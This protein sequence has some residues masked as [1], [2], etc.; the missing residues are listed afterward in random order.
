MRHLHLDL[1]QLDHLVRMVRQRL[2]KLPLP[3]GTGLR[4]DLD[5]LGRFQPCLAMPRMPRFGARSTL[6]ARAD[7]VF[8]IR[9]I[10]RGRTI[11]V[12]GVLGHASFERSDLACLLLNDSEQLDDQL[13]HDK[14]GPCPTGGIQRKP[15]WQ[16]DKGR[17]Y[18]PS[19]PATTAAMNGRHT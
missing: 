19:W 4:R 2:G 16:W 10:G 11:G 1:G 3:T 7:W 13:A 6:P 5:D 17:H 12:L 18:S 8:R 9:W 14:R 15:C